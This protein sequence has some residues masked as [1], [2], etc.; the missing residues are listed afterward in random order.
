[1]PKGYIL[2]RRLP[3]GE[4]KAHL[5]PF[6]SIPK[7]AAAAG[8]CLADNGAA[9]SA[10][11]RLFT[12]AL[13]PRP[14]GTV[15]GHDSGYDFRILAADFTADGVAIT[16]GLAVFNFYDRD[17]GVIEADQ[18]LR[19]DLSGPGGQYFDGWYDFRRDG[20]DRSYKKLNGERLATKEN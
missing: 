19:E 14:L 20:E 10:A 18:F 13:A 1:M 12:S 6:A 15:W 2:I 17:W 7:A 4:I 9:D 16:P 5:T 11:A 8:R 3:T